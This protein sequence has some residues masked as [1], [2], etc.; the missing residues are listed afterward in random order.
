MNSLEQQLEASITYVQEKKKQMSTQAIE[1]RKP[2]GLD[3]DWATLQQQARTLV[4]SGFLPRAINTPEKA[5]AVALAGRELGL[6]MMQAFRGL[7]IIEG[8][9]TMSADLMAALVFKRFPGALLRVTESTNS[10]CIIESGRAGQQATTYTFTLDDAKN[11][12][13]LGKDNWRKWPRAMLRA[14]CL[15]EAARATFADALLGVYDPDEL[16]AVTTETGDI[17]SEPEP[18]LPKIEPTDPLDY[19]P[20]GSNPVKLL[21]MLKQ[22]ERFMIDGQLDEARDILG[23]QARMIKGSVAVAIQEEIRAGNV[24]QEF[25][26]QLSREWMRINRRLKKLEEE[27]AAKL[28]ATDVTATFIDDEERAAIEAAEREEQ[29]TA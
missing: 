24:S 7:H 17:L 18:T 29:E 1:V 12:G 11:A 26:K 9:I 21:E 28:R 5:I 13:L 15:A 27:H 3:Q 10:R 8:K 4:A 22:S 14:R 20:Q 2:N 6:P 19:N 23:S 25:H 16:G